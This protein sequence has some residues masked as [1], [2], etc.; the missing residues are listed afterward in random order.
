ME[1]DEELRKIFDDITSYLI[2]KKPLTIL[3]LGIIIFYISIILG[4]LE[5]EKKKDTT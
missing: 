4:C 1:M 2:K 5:D 3:L